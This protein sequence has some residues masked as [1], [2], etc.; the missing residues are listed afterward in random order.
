MSPDGRLRH[1]QIVRFCAFSYSSGEPCGRSVHVSMYFIEIPCCA[2]MVRSD[3]PG[4]GTLPVWV[5]FYYP[6]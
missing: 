6:L 1:W 3:S 4:A 5:A 2:E